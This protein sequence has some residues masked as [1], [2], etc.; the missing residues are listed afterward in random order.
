MVD[1]S[2]VGREDERSRRIGGRASMWAF[3]AISALLLS[4]VVQHAFVNGLGDLGAVSF[5]LAALAFGWA[6]YVCTGLYYT[7]TM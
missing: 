6:V 5:E 2:L 1:I 3:T 7:R 4:V